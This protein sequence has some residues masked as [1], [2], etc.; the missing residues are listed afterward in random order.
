MYAAAFIMSN[1]ERAVFEKVFLD[2]KINLDRKKFCYKKSFF[3]KWILTAISPN[4]YE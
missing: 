4:C 2:L 3:G 1:V